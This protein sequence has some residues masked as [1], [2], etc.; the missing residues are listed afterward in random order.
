[1]DLRLE[2]EILELH[3]GICS[4]LADPKRIMILYTVAQAPHNVGEL[5]EELRMAPTTSRHLKVLRER[6]LVVG[7]RDGNVVTYS[8]ADPQLIQAID[9]LRAVLRGVYTRRAAV[10]DHTDLG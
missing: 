10:L 8:L 5:A 7:H 6:G 2:Q 4:A 3:N 9:L 1:M